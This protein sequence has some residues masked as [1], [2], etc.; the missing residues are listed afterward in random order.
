MRR[1][2]QRGQTL[3]MFAITMLF[4]FLSLVAL[5]GDADTL[6]VRYNQIN[7]EALLGAQ[8]GAGD[9]FVNGLYQNPPVYTLDQGAQ[10]ACEGVPLHGGTPGADHQI[11]CQV[12]GNTVTA[13]VSWQVGLPLPLPSSV[14][15]IQATRTAQAVFGNQQVVA[16]P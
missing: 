6:M 2:G 12:N 5:V 16:A 7:S 11:H 14:A 13:I 15:T 3:I 10:G 1:R 4:L 8:T 9:V